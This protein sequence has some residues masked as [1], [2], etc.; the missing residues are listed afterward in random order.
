MFHTI[1]VVD[2]SIFN[3]KKKNCIAT[4]DW[5]TNFSFL[6]VSRCVNFVDQNETKMS[7]YD[8]FKEAICYSIWVCMNVSLCN[9]FGQLFYLLYIKMCICK[10][11]I[12]YVSLFF[13]CLIYIHNKLITNYM[14]KIDYF[15]LLHFR[16]LLIDLFITLIW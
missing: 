3:K 10:Q 7:N 14:T 8:I 5:N 9:D 11:H 15:F 1:S 4:R 2:V 12:D 13:I 16:L 6:Y